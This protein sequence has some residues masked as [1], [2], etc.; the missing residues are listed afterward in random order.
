MPAPKDPVAR[1]EW[2]AK[3]S[4]V[5]K[6]RGFGKW[7]KGRTLSDSTRLKMSKSN[8]KIFNT[9]EMRENLSK[10][11]KKNGYG[12]WM[13]GR[14]DTPFLIAGRQ[15]AME[16]KGKSYEEIYGPSCS[17]DER[18]K[19]REGNISAWTAKMS[20]VSAMEAQIAIG[21]K[22]AAVTLEQRRNKSYEEIYGI[23]RASVERQKRREG[24][25]KR[26]ENRIRKCDLRPYQ[27]GS[28]EYNIWRTSVF[29]RDNYVCQFCGVNNDQLNAHHVHEWAGFPQERFDVEN[30]LTLCQ[31]C[32]RGLHGELYVIARLNREMEDPIDYA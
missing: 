31:C 14:K 13:R 30:G 5:A 29:K 1:A 25:R 11:A 22:G 6:E 26:W 3:L 10:L 21:L 15:Q 20:S 28:T 12:K 32:H 23:A 2:K 19:R 9:P 7:M 24:H 8:K 16:R 27:G 4:K 18:R 17:E